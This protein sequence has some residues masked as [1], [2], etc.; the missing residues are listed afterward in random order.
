[1]RCAL[2]G[3]SGFT[4]ALHLQADSQA[5]T[6]RSGGD[7]HLDDG[8]TRFRSKRI[9]TMCI[10]EPIA[11][12]LQERGFLDA[13]DVFRRRLRGLD[14]TGRQADLERLELCTAARSSGHVFLDVL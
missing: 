9:L 7:Y 10:R 14:L 4:V 2:S 6:E 3:S 1:M 13:L 5:W 11:T 8:S 12:R